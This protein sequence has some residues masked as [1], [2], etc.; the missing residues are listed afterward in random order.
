MY[1]CARCIVL[2]FMVAVVVV[3]AVVAVVVGVVAVVVVVGVVVVGF[4]A[5]RRPLGA[6]AFPSLP[7]LSLPVSVKKKHSSGEED[8][9]GN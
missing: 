8:P 9:G 5:F 2:S 7:S 6:G 1:V 3:V 4:A